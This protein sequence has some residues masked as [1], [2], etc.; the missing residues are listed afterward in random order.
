MYLAGIPI[1][2]NPKII[3]QHRNAKT[4]VNKTIPTRLSKNEIYTNLVNISSKD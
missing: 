1:S 2:I 4:K 3:A